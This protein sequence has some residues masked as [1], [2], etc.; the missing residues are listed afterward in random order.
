[1]TLVCWSC[2]PEGGALHWRYRL[3]VASFQCSNSRGGGGFARLQ[4]IVFSS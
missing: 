3:V 1:M 2:G 4:F